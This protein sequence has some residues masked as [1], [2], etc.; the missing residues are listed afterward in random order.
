VTTVMQPK[1]DE[2]FDYQPALVG[3]ERGFYR[4]VGQASRLVSVV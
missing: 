3:V 1:Q 2:T 4:F